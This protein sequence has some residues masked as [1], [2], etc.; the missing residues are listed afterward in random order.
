VLSAGRSAAIDPYCARSDKNPLTKL[1]FSHPLCEFLF[2]HG[3]SGVTPSERRKSPR[4]SNSSPAYSRDQFRHRI[5]RS[6]LQRPPPSTRGADSVPLEPGTF[7][8]SAYFTT[9]SVT[10]HYSAFSPSRRLTPGNEFC[11]GRIRKIPWCVS[12]R[13]IRQSKV[14]ALKSGRR[15]AVLSLSTRIPQTKIPP[16]SSKF[17]RREH[18]L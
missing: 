8:N 9:W 16:H 15:I 17:F 18:R 12:K 4:Y 5:G 6:P 10:P 7:T 11:Y 14:R 2:S 3:G 13:N 1:Q